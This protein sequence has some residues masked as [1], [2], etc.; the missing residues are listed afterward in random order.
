MMFAEQGFAEPFAAD[1]PVFTVD[2]PPFLLNNWRI[3]QGQ[4][5]EGYGKYAVCRGGVITI[6]NGGCLIRYDAGVPDGYYVIDSAGKFVGVNPQ[7][8]HAYT[9]TIPDIELAKPI[10]ENLLRTGP[11]SRDEVST[12]IEYLNY[13]RQSDNLVGDSVNVL[14]SGWSAVKVPK[15][16]YQESELVG[17]PEF[18]FS[19]QLPMRIGRTYDALS[20]KSVFTEMLRYDSIY[21]FYDNTTERRMPLVVGHTWKN[22]ALVMCSR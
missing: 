12:F 15:Y 2:Q 19:M 1:L 8:E 22:C 21:M 3:T 17:M 5:S 13:I 18:T 14:L 11:F 10:P 6:L 4:A 20:L 16:Y 7:S 9:I